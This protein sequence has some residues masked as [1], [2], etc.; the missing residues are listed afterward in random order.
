MN[1]R[2]EKNHLMIYHQKY[3][4]LTAWFCPLSILLKT[5][6]RKPSDLVWYLSLA[7]RVGSFSSH[8]TTNSSSYPFFRG[9]QVMQSNQIRDE[10]VYL[11]HI[12]EEPALISCASRLILASKR[13]EF[14]DLDINSLQT[15]HIHILLG[16]SSFTPKGYVWWFLP[17]LTKPLLMTSG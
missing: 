14:E 16:K 9:P 17:Y 13:W 1:Y 5:R 4:S 8:Y 2:P 6:N 3:L 11:S 7:A 10:K 12:S 15:A